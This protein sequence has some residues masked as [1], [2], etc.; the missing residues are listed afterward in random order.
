MHSPV[1][2]IATSTASF[3]PS[4]TPK[5]LSNK[6]EIFNPITPIP[7]FTITFASPENDTDNSLKKSNTINADSYTDSAYEKNEIVRFKNEILQS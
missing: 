5:T 1:N 2:D 6:A 7:D 4:Q 3:S